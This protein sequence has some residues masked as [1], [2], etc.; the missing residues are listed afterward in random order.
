MKK[1]LKGRKIF[2]FW[3]TVASHTSGMWRK[4][5]KRPDPLTNVWLTYSPYN[6]CTP[7]NIEMSAHEESNVLEKTEESLWGGG[8]FTNSKEESMNDD[9]VLFYPPYDTVC[10]R[11]PIKSKYSTRNNIKPWLDGGTLTSVSAFN[12]RKYMEY[13]QT[14]D[15]TD[16]R[17]YDD[18]YRNCPWALHTS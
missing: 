15:F 10:T 14:I 6:D 17:S 1:K 13:K 3:N 7:F 5:D 16:I 9:D 4:T 8:I 18:L 2:S 12:F 11:I